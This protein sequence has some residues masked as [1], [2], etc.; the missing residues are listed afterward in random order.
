M[1]L[2]KKLRTERVEAGLYPGSS[3]GLRG[4]TQWN[5]ERIPQVKGEPATCV[6][7]PFGPML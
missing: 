1:P 4:R 6:R 5:W 7:A 2:K 3:Q